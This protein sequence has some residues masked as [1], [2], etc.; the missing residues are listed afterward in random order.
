M[1]IVKSA[2][3]VCL[4]VVLASALSVLTTAY[5]VN[6]YI[7]SVLASF[8]IKLDGP[9][10]GIGGFV[11]SLTG[12]GAKADADATDIKDD[13]K[14][15][16]PA[17]TQTDKERTGNTPAKDSD[18][19]VE[20]KVPED[21]LAVMGEAA[22]ADKQSDEGLDQQLVMTPD[23]MSDLK[24]SLPAEEKA[25]IFNIL[26]T[27]LPQE[28]MQ[29]ISTAMEDG[30]TESEVKEIQE[31]IAKYVNQDEYEMLMKMLTP[32]ADENAQH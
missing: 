8:D 19:A 24:D 26:M 25:N 11:K 2:I 28:E 31:V 30:L 20:E 14:D 23:A 5:V 27:K 17:A 15:T 6:T 18:K 3:G 32:E 12:M 1:K 9:E 16:V 4:I 10:P 13:L 29:K 22:D 21:A 7:Q